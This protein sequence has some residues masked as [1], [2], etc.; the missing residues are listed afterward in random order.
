MNITCKCIIFNFNSFKNN[1][2]ENESS[3]WENWLYG[4]RSRVTIEF[5]IKII[6]KY[7]IPKEKS[8]V[9]API[10]INLQPIPIYPTTVSNI[11]INNDQYSTDSSTGEA[12][13]NCFS[14]CSGPFFK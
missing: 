12:F 6:K 5:L 2:R 9:I 3:T 4:K 13:F 14:C 10:T 7:R 8:N 1:E 11:N